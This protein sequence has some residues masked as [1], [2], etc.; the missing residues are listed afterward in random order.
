LDPLAILG[1]AADEIG[2]NDLADDI[3]RS[4]ERLREGRFLANPDNAKGV[5]SVEVFLPS[6][7]LRDG[8]C[9]VDTPG[10]G[11]VFG[12]NTEATRAVVPHKDAAL[13]VLGADPPLSGVEMDLVEE[14]SRQMGRVLVV[15]N[16]ADRLTEDER[17]QGRAFAARLL[18]ERLGR[19]VGPILEVSAKERLERGPTLGAGRVAIKEDAGRYLDR[20][21]ETNSARARERLHRAGPRE[22]APDG[23]GPAAAH[24]LARGRGRS[25][26]AHR[27]RP[28]RGRRECSGGPPGPP[29]RL[30]SSRRFRHR[31]IAGGRSASDAAAILPRLVGGGWGTTQGR[32]K[33]SAGAGGIGRGAAAHAP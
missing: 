27:R 31:R 4:G 15:M 24:R 29:R 12:H 14:T 13:L 11:S 23:G 3:A 26:A 20:L 17:A 16:K 1:E 2:A 7:L 9:L 5:A 21:L 25:G 19:D 32:S 8:L 28:P 10:L 18:A 30:G 33:S 6:S 22:P